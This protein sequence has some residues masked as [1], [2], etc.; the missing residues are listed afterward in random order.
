MKLGLKTLALALTVVLLCVPAA[1]AK[2]G[3]G[4]AGGHGK[5]S[6]AGG[7]NSGGNGHGKP[8]WAGQ[9]HEKKA[10]PEKAGGHEKK[11]KKDKQNKHEA[12]EDAEDAEEDEAEGE[13]LNLDDLNP[14]WYC[15]TLEA[16]MDE[17]DAEAAEGGAEPGEFSS[18]DSE[19]GENDNKRNSFGKCVS[20]RAHGEDLSGA[21][22]GES[23]PTD[24][25][26]DSAGEN[27]DEGE[28]GGDQAEDEEDGEDEDG[29]LAAF[30][31][32]LVSFIRL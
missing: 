18:F 29:E 16:M 26:D 31:R 6:W 32:A 13:E 7:G 21:L 9:G 3:N 2:G 14:A 19:F 24:E 25:S 23:D 10:K 5:P 8:A 4:N 15:K 27:E 1:F 12:A 20:R 28:E 22:D 30:A 17:A 11:P